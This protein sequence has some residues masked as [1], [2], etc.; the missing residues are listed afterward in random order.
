M[1]GP[2]RFRPPNATVL[3]TVVAILAV[4]VAS[5][6]GYRL[7]EQ[8]P[9]AFEFAE[10]SVDDQSA[11]VIRLRQVDVSENRLTVDVLLRPGTAI[12]ANGPEAVR[13]PVVRLSSWTESGRLIYVHDDLAGNES[14]TS[15]VAVGDPDDWPVDSYTTDVI[16]V[17]ASVAEG[18]GRLALPAPVVVGGSVNGWHIEARMGE[19]SAPW[20]PVQTVQFTLQRTRGAH[21]MDIG[22]L[23]VLLTLPATALFVAIEMLLNR[24][25]FQPPFITWFAAMLFAVVPLRT[26]LPGAPPPGAWIDLAVILW[27]LIALAGAMVVFVIAWWRQTRLDSEP[28]KLEVT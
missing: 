7:L 25:K 16:G 13:D 12:L 1:P 17:E 21:A 28:K 6:V 26:I 5:L 23:L 18:D 22:I 15:L 9:Q 2:R 8:P 19:I 27:V 3:T 10:A 24:R 20:G 14:T 4:Y 11:V